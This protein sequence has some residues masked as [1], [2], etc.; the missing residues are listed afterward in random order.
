MMSRIEQAVHNNIGWYETICH[1][2]GID[3]ELHSGLWLS[4]QPMPRYYSNA[5][6]FSE[7]VE[8]IEPLQSLIAL[9][10]PNGFSVKEALVFDVLSH[11]WGG[12]YKGSHFRVVEDG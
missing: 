5:I 11:Q 2:Y 7:N 4:R 3:S 1:A 8:V 9:N 6:L 10:P 12:K